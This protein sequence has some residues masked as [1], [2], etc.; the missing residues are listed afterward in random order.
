MKNRTTFLPFSTVAALCAVSILA[1]LP[2]KA[3][4]AA[5][6]PVPLF[7]PGAR[8]LFQG[9]SVTDGGRGR[10]QDPNHIL[11]HS[12][13]FIIAARQGAAFPD[14][15]LTFINRGVSG[16]RVSDLAA[17]WQSDALELKPDVL[18]VLI[19]VND[20]LLG[21]RD[22]KPVSIE[23]Y[24]QAYDRLLAETVA[25][26]PRVKL[27]LGE[28]FFLRGKRTDAQY[29]EWQV[30]MPQIRVV[31]EKLAV[32][33]HAPVVH[34][35]KIFDDACQRAP[36]EYWIWDGIHPTYAGHQLMADEWER[37]YREFYVAP[38]RKGN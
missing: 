18:S 36:V 25:A 35:Q 17:R 10:N 7:N 11:G 38:A 3:A 6:H 13:V 5:A 1:L 20:V 23:M 34:Y 37:V 27:M 21:F 15:R 29:A 9:D 16:N 31:V 32:K 19:G 30:T 4:D 12:Y 22:S 33:Y 14:L 2:V 28:P 24:E 26:M 8:V